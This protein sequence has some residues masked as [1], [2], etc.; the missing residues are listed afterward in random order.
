METS[1]VNGQWYKLTE[2]AQLL[3]V[4]EI[5][6]RRKARTGQVKAVLR[7][8]KYLV[9]LE[10]DKELGLYVGLSDDRVI[11]TLGRSDSRLNKFQEL[12][13]AASRP[14]TTPPAPQSDEIIKALKRTIADQETLIASLEDANQ[15]LR[16]KLWGAQSSNK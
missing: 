10:E 3:G 16:Q 14:K 1:P 2:A 5:T 12:S 11:P 13:H 15:R 9:Y 4:S 6:V 8:G 7:N